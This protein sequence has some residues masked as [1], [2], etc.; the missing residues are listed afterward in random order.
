VSTAAA[1]PGRKAPTAPVI[2][3]SRE[4]SGQRQVVIEAIREVDIR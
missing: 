3:L 2:P 4:V 1:Q